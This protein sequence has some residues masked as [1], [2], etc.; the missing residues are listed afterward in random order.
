MDAGRQS[1]PVSGGEPGPAAL[2]IGA[3]QYEV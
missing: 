1:N 3:V 2:Y